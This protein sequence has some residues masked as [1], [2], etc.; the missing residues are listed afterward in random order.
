[1]LFTNQSDKTKT[2]KNDINSVI[3][4]K[5][6]IKA[7]NMTFGQRIELGKI[8]ASEDRKSTRLNSSH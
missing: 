7:G 4:S 3:K 5:I 6:D 1:M 2:A 8:L